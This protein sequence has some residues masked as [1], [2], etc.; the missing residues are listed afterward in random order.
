MPKYGCL[1]TEL[2][3]GH[4][5]SKASSADREPGDYKAELVSISSSPDIQQRHFFVL[6]L[7]LLKILALV[8]KELFAN[9]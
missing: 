8:D 5:Q 9:S 3:T 7:M 2:Q 1:G 6:E 4:G